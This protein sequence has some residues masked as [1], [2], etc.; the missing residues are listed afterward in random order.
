METWYNNATVNF[1]TFRDDKPLT[2]K[3]L[4][5]LTPEQHQAIKDAYYKAAEG[6]QALK[7]AVC[8]SLF[9]DQHM[10]AARALRDFENIDFGKYL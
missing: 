5:R 10:H 1:K 8:G 9:V 6:L 4:E 3:K 7:D 2:Q